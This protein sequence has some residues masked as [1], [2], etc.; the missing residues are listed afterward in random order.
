MSDVIAMFA[1]ALALVAFPINVAAPVIAACILVAAWRSIE[2]E[3]AS[4]CRATHEAVERSRT[5][6]GALEKR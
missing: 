1:A 6:L 5:V 4:R 2:R 3:G